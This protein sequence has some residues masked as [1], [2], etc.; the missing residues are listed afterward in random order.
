VGIRLAWVLILFEA[1]V[2]RLSEFACAGRL[3]CAVFGIDLRML[4]VSADDL[5]AVSSDAARNLDSYLL[6]TVR[7]IDRFVVGHLR[8]VGSAFCPGPE[9]SICPNHMGEHGM[10][11]VECQR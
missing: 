10:D 2:E 4:L 9:L 3:R 1:C 11:P 5:C 7:T 6:V 8:L